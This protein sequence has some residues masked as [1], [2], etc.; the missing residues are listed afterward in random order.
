MLRL[1]TLIAKGPM[2]KLLNC[3]L[4]SALTGGSLCAGEFNTVQ[5]IGDMAP[6][7]SEL[8][9]VDGKTYS[10]QDFERSEIVVVVFTCNGC[11]YA[12]D[13][14]DRINNLAKKWRSDD[15]RVSVVAINSNKTEEDTLPA[16]SA[17]AAEKQFVF[18]YLRDDTQ[19]IAKAYG[20]GRTPEF[21]V[22]D[23]QRRIVY[24]GSFDDNTREAEV[25]TKYV[26]QAIDATL[27]GSPV[28]ISETPP[29][30]CAIRFQ[31]DRR[32]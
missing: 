19:K 8:P 20:A 27:A 14:E 2:F 7:W 25:K 21:F 32:R 17:R 12:I 1:R 15:A 9:G 4:L 16:M 23:K 26:E 30:G 24:M 13:Y 22:L 6:T 29:V 5:N 11:P 31:R 18:P 3:V 10:L 28:A